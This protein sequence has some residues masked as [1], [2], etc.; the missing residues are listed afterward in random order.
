MFKPLCSLTSR[1]DLEESKTQ[2][3]LYNRSLQDKEVCY[4]IKVLLGDKVTQSR[5]KFDP[6]GVRESF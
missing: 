5:R 3:Y 4:I 6:V 1:Q 2:S